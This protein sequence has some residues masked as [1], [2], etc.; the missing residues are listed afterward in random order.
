MKLNN[1]TIGLWT[2]LLFLGACRMASFTDKPGVSVKE[3]PAEMIGT[4]IQIEKENGISDTH[5]LVITSNSAKLNDNMIS[6]G[7]EMN[8]TNYSITHLGDFH[9]LNIKE[10]DST[11]KASFVVYPF[12]YNSKSL[13]VYKIVL[14]SKNLKRMKKCGL[15]ESGRRN[16]E[17]VMDNKAFKRFV[18]KYMKRKDALKFIKIK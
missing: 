5:N 13:L 11:G 12:E 1:K 2:L 9:Y 18:E 4:Y 16:G 15:M 3:F 17:F 14:S 8:D 10:T 7:F 6:Y